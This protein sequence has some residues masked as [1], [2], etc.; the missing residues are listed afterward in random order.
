MAKK[1]F[2][3]ALAF[4][5]SLA[6]Q[7]PAVPAGQ[8]V[9]NLGP[10]TLLVL[11]LAPSS[12][13]GQVVSGSLTAPAHLTTADGRTSSEVRGPAHSSPIVASSWKGNALS[14]TVRNPRDASDEDTLLFSRKD[15]AHA[16]LRF[17]IP[18]T[19]P[20][21]FPA[22]Q[23]ERAEGNVAVAE[24]W[25]PAKTYSPDDA[26]SSN[27]AMKRIY[28][29][30]QKDREAGLKIDWTAVNKSDAGRRE[31]TRKLL[32]DGALHTGEDFTWAAFV[33][34]HGATPA[35]FLLA[36]TL[37]MVAVGKGRQNALWIASA[38]L[39]RYLSSV[40]QPQI[41]GTQFHSGLDQPM[42]QEPYDRDLISDSLR[43]QLGVPVNSAQ[44]EQLKQYEKERNK[45]PRP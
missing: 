43:Q 8:W 32:R 27:P 15:A 22:F 6:A 16:E 19:I 17:D 40:K 25:D 31:E 18:A 21:P 39:D 35:D 4:V 28:D 34:Q 7:T 23:L 38:T 2:L 1:L 36:H 33:F 9:V 13:A 42:T 20:V 12:T 44:Q 29:E 11:S 10:R 3:L 30:D 26:V 24:D 41:Y 5:V 45:E 37:A 14:I